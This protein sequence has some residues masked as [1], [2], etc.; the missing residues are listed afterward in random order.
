MLR[1]APNGEAGSYLGNLASGGLGMKPVAS[2]TVLL[3]IVVAGCLAG[4]QAVEPTDL[5]VQRDGSLIVADW[6]DGQRPRR[7]R[8]QA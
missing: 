5:V 8:A 1:Q 3:P 4:C 2:L 7:G 6:A